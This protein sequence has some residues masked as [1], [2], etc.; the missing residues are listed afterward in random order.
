MEKYAEEVYED[1]TDVIGFVD[2]W[3]ETIEVN[4][5]NALVLFL[6][7]VKDMKRNLEV[8]LKNRDMVHDFEDIDIADNVIE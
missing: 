6:I 7:I 5:K 1:I 3:K 4:E 2:D 8:Y